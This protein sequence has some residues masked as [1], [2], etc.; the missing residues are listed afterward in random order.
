LQ[1]EG[2]HEDGYLIGLNS[3]IKCFEALVS[4]PTT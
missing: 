1:K 3:V 2:E 4:R